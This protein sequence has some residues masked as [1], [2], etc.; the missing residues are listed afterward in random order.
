MKAYVD[1]LESAQLVGICSVRADQGRITIRCRGG[2]EH[3]KEK[4]WPREVKVHHKRDQLY[5]IG[6]RIG[7]GELRGHFAES[8]KWS[9]RCADIGL[10]RCI[11][12]KPATS[13]VSQ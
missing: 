5:E 10:R 8:L 12:L 3:G 7:W 1:S 2:I 11:R 6:Q 4:V 13:E 9:A